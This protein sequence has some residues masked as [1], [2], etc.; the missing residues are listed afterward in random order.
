LDVDSDNN[1]YFYYPDRSDHEE[2]IDTSCREFKRHRKVPFQFVKG[3][4][5]PSTAA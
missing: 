2:L 4:F 3:A 1:N 5:G